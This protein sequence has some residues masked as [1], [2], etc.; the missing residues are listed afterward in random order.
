M[1]FKL[2][3]KKEKN[4]DPSYSEKDYCYLIAYCAC[5]GVS[6]EDAKRTGI[7]SNL[8]D[9]KKALEKKG[10]KYKEFRTS[11]SN[12]KK[13]TIDEFAN[14]NSTG[15]YYLHCKNKDPRKSGHAVAIID[16]T[17]YDSNRHEK[18]YMTK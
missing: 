16:G 15:V 4:F 1:K 14:K 18:E 11:F 17:I 7:T 2:V 8:G 12:D 6:L 10:C 5:F 13:W 9:I 3:E